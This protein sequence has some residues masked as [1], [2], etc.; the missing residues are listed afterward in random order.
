MPKAWIWCNWRLIQDT[1]A[2]SVLRFSGK[3]KGKA[4]APP[5]F[6][7]QL[8]GF[9]TSA[10]M[11]H[12]LGWT[13]R[14][15]RPHF[16]QEWSLSWWLV[17]KRCSS[18]YSRPSCTTSIH[19]LSISAMG[20][21]AMVSMTFHVSLPS[22]RSV[23][24][25]LPENSSVLD[26]KQ[27]ARKALQKPFCSL[28]LATVDGH[29]LD[30][31]MRCNNVHNCLCSPSVF[32][33]VLLFSGLFVPIPFGQPK[34][35]KQLLHDCVVEDGDYLLAVALPNLTV[36]ATERSFAFCYGK[37]VIT[38]GDLGRPNGYDNHQ[39][40][41]LHQEVRQ[42]VASSGSFV[43]L[44]AD[45][46]LWRGMDRSDCSTQVH[47]TKVHQLAASKGAFAAVL[48]DGS[49]VT[50][51]DP[52]YGGDTSEVEHQLQQV[53]HICGAN[54]AF[55]AILASGQVVTWGHPDRGGDSGPVQ[56]RLQQ[57]TEII[58]SG[59]AFA[60]ILSD[61]QV[62]TWG[63]PE[64]GGDSESVQH[65]LQNVQKIQST[66]DAFAAITADNQVVTWGHSFRGGDCRQV[67][68]QLQSVEDIQASNSAFAAILNNGRVVTWGDPVFG[69]DSASVQD[70]LQNVVQICA[71]K[72]AFAA[73]LE[74]GRVV[75]WG[76]SK[77]GGDS[78]PAQDQLHNICQ[79]YSS[80][81]AFVAIRSDEHVIAWGDPKAGG[82]TTA[83]QAELENL[84]GL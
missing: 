62:V 42:I 18:R 67:Q 5:V 51:G 60:A 53:E 68:D 7:Q 3:G 34:D 17:A 8:W 56:H 70:Q 14:C 84:K 38:W 59:P 73:R 28:Q 80:A 55:A 25:S 1:A 50:W 16:L 72:M 35:S 10:F 66:N 82:C 69:G 11:L 45:G 64:R 29:V 41:H 63:D 15:F 47:K 27:A 13:L 26:L 44:L 6:R 49:A 23:S 37:E 81:G 71:S 43:A 31:R 40:R 9:D 48:S 65:Q 2:V 54:A 52:R 19:N 61:G 74:D 58:S 76:D 39:V 83:V 12:V 77:C 4:R 24:I 46:T 78:T 33:I 79:L 36:A 21:D 20:D 32:C 75:T 22:G 57:V 30:T